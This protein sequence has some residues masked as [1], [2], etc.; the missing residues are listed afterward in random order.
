MEDIRT[1]LASG[2][3]LLF[4]GAM[5]TYYASLPGPRAASCELASLEAPGEILEIHR[6]YL[7]AGCQAIKTNTFSAGALKGGA[8]LT[9]RI[10]KESCKL[11]LEAA[12]PY[13]AYV[14][15][16]MGPLP[17][18]KIEAY[19]PQVDA[20]LEMGITHFLAETLPSNQG[21]ETL[22]RHL[23]ACC[24]EAF[25]LVSFAVQPEGVTLEGY[26]GGELLRWADA[27]PEIDS[28]GFNCM[29]GPRHMASLLQKLP[30]LTKP[31]SA[32]PNGGYPTVLGRRVVYRGKP[33]YFGSQAA[34]LAEAGA[35]IIGGC[36]GT[37]P[38]HMAAVAK[39]L[40]AP[41]RPRPAAPAAPQ[42]ARPQAPAPNPLWE[43]L[44]ACRPVIAVELDPPAKGSAAPFLEGAKRLWKAGADAITIA[45][46]P[47]GRPRADS[48]LLACKLKRELGIEPLP[49]LT[50]RDRNLSATRALLLGLAMEDV[51]NVLLVTGD[52]MPSAQRDEVKSVFQFNA[53]KLAKYVSAMNEEVF[54]RPLR[55]YGALN[56][57]A[58]NFQ[59]QLRLAQEKEENGVS[60]FLTQPVLSPEALA[61][62]KLARSIL[63]GKILGGI[64]PV[65][66]YRNACFL[67]NEIAGVQV[68]DEI[69]SRYEG[70]DRAEAE[71]LALGI[72][73]AIAREMLPYVDGFYLM[74]P[75]NRIE[76]M[77]KIINNLQNHLF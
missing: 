37:T 59:M 48:S 6:A 73:C 17:E 52:P 66:S 30:P 77:E 69:V 20:F 25:L 12:E 70:K 9:K 64:Y 58:R 10:I 3:P 29:A 22:A 33:D 55:L 76:L 67:N 75:F 61:N 5:G 53:R 27:L 46:C 60:A 72:S 63:K 71:A 32:L 68:C 11:A 54:P 15:A 62:L 16:D 31:L 47:V 51:S 35:Q 50:C 49:H 1:Y 13:G 28:M 23:K 44:E 19:L 14:F 56:L 65:V 34:A 74:T 18:D 7:S 38:A 4:D 42:A 43:K 40:D 57:N 36:C 39:A 41:S 2:R 26:G 21:L 24:P 8:A 45:D